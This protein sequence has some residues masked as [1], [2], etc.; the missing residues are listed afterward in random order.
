MSP[1]P[2]NRRCLVYHSRSIQGRLPG[3]VAFALKQLAPFYET[4]VLACDTEL[5][6]EDI[7]AVG[8]EGLVT[9]FSGERNP[10][11]A[12]S[13]FILGWNPTW[14]AGFDAMTFTHSDAFGP[15]SDP[16]AYLSEME[17]RDA[18]YFGVTNRNL[19]PLFG[20]RSQRFSH[21]MTRISGI[22]PVDSFFISFKRQVFANRA[23]RRIWTDLPGDTDR[24]QMERV[25]FK[26]LRM[27]G[28]KG[29]ALIDVDSLTD[30]G[31]HLNRWNHLLDSNAPF[32]QIQNFKLCH[33]PK[34]V[35]EHL[36]RRLGLSVESLLGRYLTTRFPPHEN[37]D[38]I[39]KN[40]L[41]SRPGPRNDSARPSLSVHIHVFY[42]DV[43]DVLLENFH[44]TGM[45]IDLYI[46]TPLSDSV[47]EIA[48]ITNPYL[49]RLRLVEVRVVDNV[50]RDVLP[51]LTLGKSLD[52]YDIVGHF[53]TKKSPHLGRL[54]SGHWM[55]HILDT[56][57]EPLEQIATEM[58]SDPGIGIVIPDIHFFNKWQNVEYWRNN[59]KQI[60]SIL[61]KLGI[62]D[63]VDLPKGD[64]DM[65]FSHGSMLWYK[66]DALRAMMS[67]DWNP[68]EFPREPVATDG[69]LMHAIERIPVYAA[70]ARGYDYRI[71]LNPK[72]Q[73]SV[74]EM[75]SLKDLVK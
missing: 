35:L 59:E 50:G 28:F 2:G 21:F 26:G 60:R 23:F 47:E 62:Q 16:G 14:A 11:V 37:I 42:L 22:K 45:E 19:G 41:P 20:I 48:A 34:S 51:W 7:D 4:V 3:H 40:W 61:D 17:S 66:P 36:T 24:Y 9:V 38:F 13:S 69:T 58:H 73:M 72:I 33:Q 1:P 63:E 6:S 49:D 65:V 55:Q 15:L 70:W 31:W 71:M 44:R 25:I 43:Y 64:S 68:E 75:N 5:P 67:H 56:M 74:W 29:D 30:A 52:S 27:A 53:H 32:L 54:E 39:N 10:Y 12:W 46:T 57:V 8:C 18:D